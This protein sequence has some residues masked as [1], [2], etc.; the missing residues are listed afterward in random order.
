[1]PCNFAHLLLHVPCHLLLLQA[2]SRAV[3]ANW[4]VCLA[5]WCA[6]ASPGLLGKLMAIWPPILSFCAFG[7]EHRWECW[8][9]LHIQ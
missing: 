3:L 2:S 5:V 6:T 8:L 9:S 1:M 7:G 4:F